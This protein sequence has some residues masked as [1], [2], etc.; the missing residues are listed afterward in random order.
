[1]VCA[2]SRL[3]AIVNDAASTIKGG[4]EP[5][6]GHEPATILRRSA[7]IPGCGA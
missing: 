1:V 6:Y 4:Q 5:G 7:V 3:Q 2:R